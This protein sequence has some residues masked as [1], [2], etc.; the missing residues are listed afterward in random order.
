MIHTFHIRKYE[1]VDSN[2]VRKHLNAVLKE[3]IQIHEEQ[4]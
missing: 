3:S 2:S 4:N 1:N